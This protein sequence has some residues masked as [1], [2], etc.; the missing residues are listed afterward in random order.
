MTEKNNQDHLE[1]TPMPVVNDQPA[2]EVI[3]VVATSADTAV[4]DVAPV[5]DHNLETETKVFEAAPASATEQAPAQATERVA[6]QPL[7]N[8]P[9]PHE[10][11]TGIAGTAGGYPAGQQWTGPNAHQTPPVP[12][13]PQAPKVAAKQPSGPRASTIVWGLIIVLLGVALLLGVLGF[14]LDLQLFTIVLFGVAGV[15]LVASAVGKSLKR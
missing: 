2:T 13:A 4:I 6:A 7:H 10:W 8:D 5:S 3:D 11:T 14:T 12:P 15:A 1:T 9:A